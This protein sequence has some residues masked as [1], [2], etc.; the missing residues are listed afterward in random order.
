VQQMLTLL[1][2]SCGRIPPMLGVAHA[3]HRQQ[4]YYG[5]LDLAAAKVRS[6]KRQYA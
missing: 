3:P 2:I 4:D 5:K 1:R 6:M